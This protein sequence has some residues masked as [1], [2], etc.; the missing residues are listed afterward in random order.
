MPLLLAEGLILQF[1]LALVCRKLGAYHWK[2]GQAGLRT[3]PPRAVA[4]NNENRKKVG[5]HI[6]K[7]SSLR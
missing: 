7:L 2:S 5:N 6:C 3:T 4:Q 1:F